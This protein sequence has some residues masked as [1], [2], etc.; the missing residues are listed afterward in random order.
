M[1]NNLGD[2]ITIFDSERSIL[3]SFN[4]TASYVFRKLKQKKEKTEITDSLVKTFSITKQ[5]AEKDVNDILEEMVRS[6]II[7]IIEEK[8]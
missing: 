4:K 1:V 5:R 6:N 2:K 8:S 3:Y 7:E